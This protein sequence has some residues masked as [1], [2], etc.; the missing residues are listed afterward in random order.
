MHRMLR[1]FMQYLPF[2]EAVGTYLVRRF[3]EY[4]GDL[5]SN[6]AVPPEA[7]EH[8]VAAKE[9]A[10][11]AIS[12]V[13][14]DNPSMVAAWCASRDKRQGVS[15]AVVRYWHL[16]IADQLTFA[17]KALTEDSANQVLRSN[18]F[19]DEAKLRAMPRATV[20]AIWDWLESDPTGLSDDEWFQAFDAAC[21]RRGNIRLS[22]TAPYATLAQRPHLAQRLVAEG[23]DPAAMVAVSKVAHI[24]ASAA[25]ERVIA[26]ADT[27][28]RT[29]GL[30]AL[31]DHPSL[32][33]SVRVAAFEYATQQNQLADVY[34]FGVPSPGSVLDLGTPLSTLEDPL[35]V[36]LVAMRA[37][38]TS[39]PRAY[40]FVELAEAPGAGTQLLYRFAEASRHLYAD[41]PAAARAVQAL[42]KRMD[43]SAIVDDI[44][45]T[46][47]ASLQAYETRRAEQATA[48]QLQAPVRHTKPW[49]YGYRSSSSEAAPPRPEDLLECPLDDLSGMLVGYR[50]S[51]KAVEVFTELLVEQLG[52][53]TTDASLAKWEQC[54]QLFARTNGTMRTRQVIST[55]ARLR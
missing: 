7:Y 35:T 10:D 4:V 23:C 41:A 21:A 1:T 18:G 49:S 15:D 46:A 12:L 29:L 26:C 44:M 39:A 47:T 31:L 17:S 43:L 30:V 55:A 16:P 51:H 20:P 33:A 11:T 28:T 2:P 19:V 22:D 6:T 53:G 8:I 14:I 24:D 27:T 50:V 54:M 25:L 40:H 37:I 34:R 32:P 52:D 9:K 5:L 42:A 13:T 45:P 48:A 3:P 38:G 36:E